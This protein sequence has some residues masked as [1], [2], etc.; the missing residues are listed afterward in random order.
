MKIYFGLTENRACFQYKNMPVKEIVVYCKTRLKHTF[1]HVPRAQNALFLMLKYVYIYIHTY[2][3]MYVCMRRIT[4]FPSTT[5]R[6]NN[7]DP[8]RL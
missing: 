8:I 5:D 2:I 7:G 1:V 4:K 6:I 3:C